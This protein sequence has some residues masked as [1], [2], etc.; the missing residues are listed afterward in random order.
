MWP[1]LGRGWHAA[2]VEQVTTDALYAVYLERQ[3]ADIEASEAR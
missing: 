2:I 1:E 3:T